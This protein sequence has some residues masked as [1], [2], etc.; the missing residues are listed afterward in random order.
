MQ[1]VKTNGS[2]QDFNVNKIIARINRLSKDLEINAE[3]LAK[4]V[5][6]KLY[7]GISTSEIDGCLA[8]TCHEK[9]LQDPD[10]NLLGG[11]IL[12]TR[13]KKKIKSFT[14]TTKF[15]QD[16]LDLFNDNYLAKVAKF[17]KELDKHVDHNRDLR[18]GYI[19]YNI[20]NHN[21]L[22]KV[23]KVAVECPQYMFMREAVVVSDDNIDDILKTYDYLSNLLYTHATPTIGNAGYKNQ[24]LASCF[25][26]MIAGDDMESILDANKEFGMMSKH[27]GGVGFPA[28]N[29]RGKNSRL[30]KSNG[31]SK[32]IMPMLKM[33]EST[34]IYIDQGGRRPGAFSPHLEPW[35]IDVEDFIDSPSKIGDPRSRTP[36]LYPGLFVNDLFM[37]KVKAGE[38]WH[39]FSPDEADGLFESYDDF[40]TGNNNFT[41]L[42]E[43]YVKEMKFRKVV[44][45][46]GLWHSICKM[47][48]ETGFPYIANKDQVNSK[49]NQKNIGTIKSLNLCQEVSQVAMPDETPVCFLVSTPLPSFVKK[50]AFDFNLYGQ[51][52]Q[53]AVKQLDNTIDVN[54]FT[55]PKCKK[56]ST[57][58]R[59]LGIGSSGLSDV[60]MIMGIP[61]DSQE[62]IKL[63]KKIA[64]ARYFHALTASCELAKQRGAYD[65]FKGSPASEGVLQ[66]HMWGVEPSSDFDWP[67]LIA[68]IIKHGLRNSLLVAQ[69]PTGTTSSIFD[70]FEACEAPTDNIVERTLS[71]GSFM[72]VNKY[73]IKKL[74]SVG[75]WTD[76]IALKILSNDGSLHGINEIPKEIKEVFK[77]VY[78]I[79]PKIY[80]DMC[81]DRA[82]FTCQSESFNVYYKNNNI[83]KVSN[84]LMY[85]YEKGLKTVSYYLRTPKSVKKGTSAANLKSKEDVVCSLTNKEACEACSS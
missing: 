51:I 40:F 74:K 42:Y 35:H 11:R 31:Y 69:M 17:G 23:D 52:I 57:R 25:L 61:Y 65:S 81:Y 73:M 15:I 56:S 68:N 39:L 47:K 53:H 44:D 84:L 76:E 16:K 1:V 8:K 66:F 24:Q 30:K 80:I 85:G 20:I 78:E 45:A 48:I 79:N 2:A 41:K 62:A 71:A 55:D 10:Y 13:H 49:S 6:E 83:G 26:P 46:R 27:S 3:E 37:K 34:A 5:Y 33:V 18:F 75:L 54:F 36:D 7:D 50:G 59:A 19:A 60:F 29:I 70:V 67:T 63:N 9:I 64:E 32:G 22:I 4:I 38:P 43:K 72:F 14:E 82:C 28:T 58:H 21:Y 77:T 12:V